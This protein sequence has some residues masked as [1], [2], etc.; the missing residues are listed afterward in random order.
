MVVVDGRVVVDSCERSAVQPDVGFG[1]AGLVAFKQQFAVAA[2]VKAG[3]EPVL[4]DFLDA[5]AECVVGVGGGLGGGGAGGEAVEPVVG[6][7]G[8]A[9]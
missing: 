7:A 9:H 1:V 6:E 8:R 3:G 4:V 5:L 2:V